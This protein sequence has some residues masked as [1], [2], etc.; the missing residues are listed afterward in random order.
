MI[1]SLGLSCLEPSPLGTTVSPPGAI[2][3]SIDFEG[4]SQLNTANKDFD[5]I[6]I[7]FGIA[8]LDPIDLD[9]GSPTFDE[10]CIKEFN[11]VWGSSVYIA[12]ASK[13]FLFGEAE[14]DEEVVAEFFEL[15]TKQS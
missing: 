7:E 6:N 10:R 8:V 9:D 5:D 12:K 15:E 14:I 2:F 4:G 3:V 1:F 13:K 11:F